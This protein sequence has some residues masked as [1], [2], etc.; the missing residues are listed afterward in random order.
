VASLLNGA[1]LWLTCIAL[2][3][4]EASAPHVYKFAH[5][6]CF[7]NDRPDTAYTTEH[8]RLHTEVSSEAAKKF[9]CDVASRSIVMA[10]RLRGVRDLRGWE[11]SQSHDEVISQCSQVV[12]GDFIR[13]LDR[14]QYDSRTYTRPAFEEIYP[15]DNPMLNNPV[16]VITHNDWTELSKQDY[17]AIG[18]R[19][20]LGIFGCDNGI[21]F[22]TSQGESVQQLNPLSQ[23]S[24]LRGDAAS[25]EPSSLA[26]LTETSVPDDTPAGSAGG[27][28]S[29]PDAL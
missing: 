27:P 19:D 25:W 6:V 1:D 24:S 18:E 21:Y 22:P 23:S 15:D 3:R 9:A 14:A 11:L 7:V 8:D 16:L 13:H 10:M 2:K 26:G 17:T 29:R 28:V 4:L 5:K 12:T 20:S